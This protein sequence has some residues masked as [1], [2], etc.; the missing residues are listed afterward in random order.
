VYLSNFNKTHHARRVC[1]KIVISGF[2]LSGYISHMNW[3]SIRPYS[4]KKK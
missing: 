1:V 3:V 4:R 2:T